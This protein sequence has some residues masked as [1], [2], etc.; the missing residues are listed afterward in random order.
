MFQN[1]TLP[2]NL[3]SHSHTMKNTSLRRKVIIR[4][5]SFSRKMLVRFLMLLYVEFAKDIVSYS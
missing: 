1:N 2:A 4:E 3:H 5:I